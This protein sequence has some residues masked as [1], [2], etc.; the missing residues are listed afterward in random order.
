MP[1]T[2][3]LYCNRCLWRHYT[4]SFCNRQSANIR[5]IEEQ[6]TIKILRHA[7]FKTYLQFPL[8][9]HPYLPWLTAY[10]YA[11]IHDV[12]DDSHQN[13]QDGQKYPIF[14]NFGKS[15]FPYV[16]DNFWRLS[17]K[18]S[19]GFFT[20]DFFFPPLNLAFSFLFQDFLSFC[21]FFGIFSKW[22]G[23]PSILKNKVNIISWDEH[24]E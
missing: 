5:R 15:M 3:M 21:F 17:I 12:T 4:A 1:K 7:L 14:T 11:V 18:L 10:S 23:I 20:C 6:R 22:F 9:Y 19:T 16:S 24:S 2:V 13:T 8:K